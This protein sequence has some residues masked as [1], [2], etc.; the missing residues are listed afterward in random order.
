MGKSILLYSRG[1]F[2]EFIDLSTGERHQMMSN[3]HWKDGDG[4]KCVTGHCNLFIF[5]Y[6]ELCQEPFIFV[7]SYPEFHVVAKLSGPKEGVK[8]LEFSETSLLFSLGDMPNY[9]VTAWNWRTLEK[10]AES[11]NELIYDNQIVKCSYGRPMYLAQLGVGSDKLFIWDVFTV[12]KS[13]IF[14]KHEVKFGELKPAPFMDVLWTSDGFCYIIDSKGNV[15]TYDRDFYLEKVMEI[16]E[17]GSLQTFMG[18]F[19]HGLII[20]GPNMEIKHYKKSSGEW[21][22]D[23]KY[24]INRKLLGIFCNK[25]DRCVALTENYEI[26]Q[27]GNSSDSLKIV[28]EDESNFMDLCLIYPAGEYV[29]TLCQDS[30]LLVYNVANGELI[31]KLTLNY[32]VCSLASNP[33]F[34]CIAIGTKDGKVNLVSLYNVH[35][36]E[37]ILNLYLTDNPLVVTT[38]FEKGYMFVTGNHY[39]GEFFIIRGTPGTQ[40]DVAVHLET[41]VQVVDFF[42]VYSQNMIRFFT[43]PITSNKFYAGNKVVRYCIVDDRVVNE[44]EYTFEENDRLFRSILPKRGPQKDRVFYLVPINT[45]Y[46][47][48]VETKRGSPFMTTVET[49]KS[50]HQI[51]HFSVGISEHYGITW[52]YDGFIIVRCFEFREQIGMCLPHHCYLQ[53]V[54]KTVVNPTGTIVVSLGIDNVLTGTLIRNDPDDMDMKQRINQLLRSPK[55]AVMFKRVTLGFTV[56]SRFGNKS[57]KDIQRLKRIEMEEET[58]RVEKHKILKEFHSIQKSLVSLVDQN[59]DAAENEKL[60]LLEFYLDTTLYN[61]KQQQNKDDCKKTEIYLK[62]LV[63]AQD[64]VSSY[65]IK[66][67]WEKMGVQWENILGIFSAVKATNYCLLP[68]NYEKLSRLSWIEEQRKVEQFLSSQDTFEPWVWLSKEKVLESLNKRPTAPKEDYSGLSALRRLKDID[69]IDSTKSLETKIALAGSVSQLYIDIS[70]GHYQ[71]RQLTSFYQC[72]LQQAVAE[73]EVTK[74]KQNYNKC[75]RNTRAIKER[76]VYNV[77]EKNARLKHILSE[78][79]Y[80]SENKICLNIEDPVWNQTENPET[81]LK[82]TEDEIPI[83]PYVS[84]SEQAILDAKAAEEER[85][86]LLLLADDFRERALMA[87][88]NGVLEIRWEDELKKDVSKPKCM[89]EK[90]PEEYNEDDLRAIRDYEEKVVQLKTEREKYKTLLEAEFV[91]L[92]TNVRDSIRKFNQKLYECTRYK[93]YIDSGMNQ[94]NLQVNRARFNQNK[95]IK[96]DEQEAQIIANIKLY[97]CAVEE[98]QKK[99][100]FMQEALNECKVNLDMM[101]SKEKNLEKAYRKEF[102]DMSP[103]VQEQSYK[104]YRRRPKVNFR[105]ISTATVLNEL[106]KGIMTNETTIAMTQECLD[107]LKSLE[108]LDQFVGL[109]PTIDE[110]TW[111]LICKQRRMRI[112]YDIRCRAAQIQIM[113]G[114]ATISTFQKR[115]ATEKE[116]IASLNQ[117]LEDTRAARLYLMHNRQV[118]VVL[119]RGLVEIP[120]TGDL[121]SDFDDAILIQ[122]SEIEHVN[123]LIINAGNLKLKTIQKNMHFKRAMMATEWEHM[124]IRMQINDLIEQKKDIDTVKFTKEMQ[125]YLKNKS[126]GRKPEVESYEMEIELLASAYENRINDKKAKYKKIMKQLKQY[127]E[128]NKELDEAIKKVNMDVSHFNLLK[129]WEVEAKEQQVLRARLSA[130]LRRNVLVQKIQENHNEILVLQT[131]LELLRLRTFPT[132]KYK[133]LD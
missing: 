65:I 7:R 38:Y 128:N 33:E 122:R 25:H 19:L 55:I 51:K 27:L 61:K 46:F 112:E 26:V 8:C 73:I 94:E 119:R 56:E 10:F 35:K 5:A 20:M 29:V 101:Q 69:D 130:M 31:S 43:L 103:V 68:E 97:E 60:D 84:P 105:N 71:Q 124:K 30:I 106:A 49:I 131:E 3:N 74:L 14:S 50:G 87:M 80:F 64:K 126:L 12:C 115:M 15:Y 18:W 9:T 66:N 93:F 120:L 70:P 118:Q 85:L 111:Q 52:G 59:L 23:W 76:E 117:E 100:A 81:I 42:M 109:P 78:Y 102:Q 89:L 34:P 24:E 110:S 83:R 95:R 44:K 16:T 57:W 41:N 72:D 28:K 48:I 91:K 77:K 39:I 99:I 32:P 82:V 98:N 129:D 104:L 108:Q 121:F 123:N 54:K 4:I 2:I 127:N 113:D 40:V 37:V 21:V 125:I 13:S 47:E 92:A 114:E 96:L 88:M 133:I 63:V 58:C 62:C 86:R 1:C 67:Y 132:F 45:R 116:K 36:P 53:G 22:C 6:A 11:K 107:Y 90:L 79:N 75:F 17:E